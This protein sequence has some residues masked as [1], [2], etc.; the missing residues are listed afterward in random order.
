MI[1]KVFQGADFYELAQEVKKRF[2]QMKTYKP[3]ACRD[4]SHE[5]YVICLGKK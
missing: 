1:L 2:D 4:S 5:E 3:L